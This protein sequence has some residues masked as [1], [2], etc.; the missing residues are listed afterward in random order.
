MTVQEKCSGFLLATATGR[1]EESQAKQ[2]S[3][4]TLVVGKGGARPVQ[5]YE[6]RS[7]LQSISSSRRTKARPP[8]KAGANHD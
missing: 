6:E 8:V 5:I 4:L 3:F 7:A 2:P 1:A